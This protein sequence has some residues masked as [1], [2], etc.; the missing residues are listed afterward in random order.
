MSSL[1]PVLNKK[2]HVQA[3][4]ASKT[5]NLVFG[6]GFLITNSKY[7]QTGKI[8]TTYQT[9]L[10]ICKDIENSEI[11][12]AEKDERKENRGSSIR[13]TCTNECKASITEFYE[14]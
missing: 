4:D 8:G 13:S 14:S 11:D 3:S 9:Y 6:L 1:P 5:L 10:D 2:T 7:W 12:D